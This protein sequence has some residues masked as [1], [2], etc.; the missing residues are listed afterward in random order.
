MNNQHILPDMY[1]LRADDLDA[2]VVMETSTGIMYTVPR[3]SLL[4]YLKRTT[5][6]LHSAPQPA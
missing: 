1:P 6:T 4:R 3:E 2:V 5:G